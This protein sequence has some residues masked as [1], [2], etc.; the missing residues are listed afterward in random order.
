M[1]K[2]YSFLFSY[3]QKIQFPNILKIATLLLLA[4]FYSNSIKSQNLSAGDIA[5]IGV[6]VDDEEVLLVALSDIPSGEAV[7]FTDDEWGGSAFNSGEGFYEWTTPSI[8]AG[9]VLTLTKTSTTVGGTITQKAGSMTLGN[10]GDG[11]FLYQT[12]TNVF[13]TGNYTILGF[14]GEDAGDAGTLTGTGLVI[15]SNAVYFGGD[16]GIYSNTRTANSKSGHLENIYDNSKWTTSGTSQTFDTSN[17]S[18]V[19]SSNPTIG[20]DAATS[21]VD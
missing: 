8:S 7:F 16:N 5:I 6:S 19:V 9:T 2:N 17:F 13:N 15:G 21:A 1:I 4:L 11:F 3:F 12:T 10:S 20:F 14:A 18:I